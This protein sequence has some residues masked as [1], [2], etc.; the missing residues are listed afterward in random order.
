[1]LIPLCIYT[2]SYFPYAVAKG[3][4]G[5]FRGMVYESLTWFFA[6]LPRHLATLS[7]RMEQMAQTMAVEDKV[8]GVL[9][10]I[11]SFFQIIPGDSANPVDIMLKNQHFM[12]TYHQGVH[13]PHPYESYWYQW[14]FDG[15][16]I[17]YYRDLDVPG[18]KSLFASFN[19]PLVSW[20]GLLAF[21]GVAIQTVRRRDGKGLFILIAILS[22]FV[23][24]L[25]IGRILFAYH[26]FPSILFLVFCICYLFNDL[27]ECQWAKW[28]LPVY[29]V[30]G[31]SIALYVLFYPALIGLTM[32]NWYSGGLL[33]FLPSWP[34]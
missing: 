17:L 16:P 26:Y 7:E 14:I 9:D 24:W 15:R 31:V 19:N 12:F 11:D 33:R 21:F 22:Q 23:P 20:A 4:T 27:M 32:P 10:W 2:V 29:G 6:E 3:N 28:R 18:M 5:G 34:F 13:N 30:T 25:P 1:M 8:P